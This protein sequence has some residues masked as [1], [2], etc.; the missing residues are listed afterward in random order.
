MTELET[1]LFTVLK[2]IEDARLAEDN[3]RWEEIGRYPNV[4]IPNEV[5]E[6]WLADLK[7]ISNRQ[8]DARNK[9]KAII[10]RL[11]ER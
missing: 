1:E 7:V 6:K 8:V 10:A 9:A 2:E 11:T 5:R 4:K 3:Y